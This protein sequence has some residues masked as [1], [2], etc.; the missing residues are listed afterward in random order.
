[1]MRSV[2]VQ[3]KV[4]RFEEAQWRV[5][6][7]KAFTTNMAFKRFNWADQGVILLDINANNLVT[8]TVYEPGFSEVAASQYLLQKMNMKPN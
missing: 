8:K 7:S 4:E 3:I 2:S 1:M 5:R 6:L